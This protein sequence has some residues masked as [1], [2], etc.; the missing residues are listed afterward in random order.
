MQGYAL[1]MGVG[2]GCRGVCPLDFEIIKL[3]AKKVV[4]SIWQV[5]IHLIMELVSNHRF[6][7]TTANGK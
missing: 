3:L 5:Q 2:R 4:F 1:H 6:T 7:L